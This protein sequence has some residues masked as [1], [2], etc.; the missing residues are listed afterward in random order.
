MTLDTLFDYATTAIYRIRQIEDDY[1]DLHRTIGALLD[2]VY[3][4]TATVPSA[5]TE[6]LQRCY[7][8]RTPSRF[9]DL[10]D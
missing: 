3:V 7:D 9:S 2:A 8:L 5:I 6:Q 10:K 1:D 4:G